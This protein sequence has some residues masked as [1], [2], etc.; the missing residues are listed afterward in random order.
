MPLSL[1]PCLYLF[2][3]LSLYVSLSLSICLS[4]SVCI[5]LSL[6]FCL[7]L[8]LFLLGQNKD[9]AGRSDAKPLW[10]PG[11]TQVNPGQL[12]S[13]PCFLR[14]H[15]VRGSTLLALKNKALSLREI[16]LKRE[17]KSLEGENFLAS[18]CL[19]IWSCAPTPISYTS[20]SSFASK[21]LQETPAMRAP[22]AQL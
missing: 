22:E 3:S 9:L 7:S 4:V 19:R 14:E 11:S 6:Y 15:W 2:L 17:N 12:T 8:E 13:K 20:I 5:S 16:N 10:R 1:S 21:F 18:V